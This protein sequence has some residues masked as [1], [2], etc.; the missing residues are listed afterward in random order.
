MPKTGGQAITR[1]LIGIKGLNKNVIW[2]M[3]GAK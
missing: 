1:S 3:I 2:A